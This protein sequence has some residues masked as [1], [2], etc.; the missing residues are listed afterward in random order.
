MCASYEAVPLTDLLDLD[1]RTLAKKENMKK[2]M[3][4]YLNKPGC[5]HIL[6]SQ[7][8]PK[9]AIMN[10]SDVYKC[11]KVKQGTWWLVAGADVDNKCLVSWAFLKGTGNKVVG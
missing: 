10:I 1:H 3:A 9:M 7:M 6:L 2:A 8:E 4:L 11:Q 5:N